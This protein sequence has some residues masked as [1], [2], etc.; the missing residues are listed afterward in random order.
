[1]AVETTQG[2]YSRRVK[3]LAVGLTLAMIGL[4]L[5]V[6]EVALRLVYDEYVPPSSADYESWPYTDLN[7]HPRTYRHIAQMDYDPFLGY[8]PTASYDGVGYHTNAQHLRYNEDLA[9]QKAPNEVRIFVTGGS[10]AWGAGVGQ[11]Q[12]YAHYL[13]ELFAEDARFDAFKIRVIP[14]GVGAYVTTQERTLLLNHLLDYEPDLIVM[15]TGANDVYHGYRGNRLLRNQDFMEIRQALAQSPISKVLPGVDP[16]QLQYDAPYWADYRIKLHWLA[17]TAAHRI[18]HPGVASDVVEGQSFPIEL[19]TSESLR[20]IH[21]MLDATRR[22]GI[23]LVLYLQPYLVASA[24]PL[25][26]WE[27]ELLK[28][29]E[30]STPG[31]P[32]YVRDAYPKYKRALADDALREGYSFFDAD[33]AI[34]AEKEAVFVDDFHLGDRGNALLARHLHGLLADRVEAIVGRRL[35]Q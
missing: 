33:V 11:H 19:T 16:S 3:I 30:A 22:I 20:N 34:Q 26:D 14:A 24:K 5:G 1:M 28:R 18:A 2:A 9:E 31:W 23:D 25:A 4:L 13:E 21:V 17:A 27:Q 10:T 15:F 35:K 12:T 6:A 32:A 7:Q 29:S 8:L